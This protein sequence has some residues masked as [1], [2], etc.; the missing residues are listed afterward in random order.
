MFSFQQQQHPDTKHQQKNGYPLK[1]A[2][3]RG[4]ESNNTANSGNGNG[5]NN[6]NSSSTGRPLG[7]I[8]L[9]HQDKN[10]DDDDDTYAVPASPSSSTSPSDDLHRTLRLRTILLEERLRVMEG[11]TGNLANCRIM[12]KN[13]Y[14]NCM[15][16]L[17][18][19]VSRAVTL[20]Q[21]MK[22]EVEKLQQR[23][24]ELETHNNTIASMI[25]PTLVSYLPFS[26]LKVACLIL[27]Q[28]WQGFLKD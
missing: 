5:N 1:S 10:K 22:T 25:L 2:I 9:H 7:P 27:L 6:S 11:L 8:Q 4:I 12:D 28:C 21:L 23:V 26:I 18:S 17:T 3:I 13:E 19:Q 14:E 16:E 24:V 15:T 20:Q